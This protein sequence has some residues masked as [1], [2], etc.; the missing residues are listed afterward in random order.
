MT[1]P[2]LSG[3]FEVYVIIG[4]VAAMLNDEASSYANKYKSLFVVI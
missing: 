1:T 3:Q 2:I 4:L